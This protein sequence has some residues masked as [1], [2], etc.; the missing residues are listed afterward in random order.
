MRIANVAGRATLLGP[1]GAGLDGGKASN[2]AFSSD[3][4]ALYERWEEFRDWA[5][6]REDGADTWIGPAELA[7]PT[8]RPRQVSRLGGRTRPVQ[9]GT[10]TAAV[11]HAAGRSRR[12][13]D[14]LAHGRLTEPGAHGW[15]TPLTT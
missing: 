8:P 1:G 6:G 2:G 4:Q 15:R 7:P 13:D 3:P 14:Q 9:P 10:S 5:A 11:L 12:T